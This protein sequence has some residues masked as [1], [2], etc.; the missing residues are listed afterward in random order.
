MKIPLFNRA[1]RGKGTPP[2]CPSRPRTSAQSLQGVGGLYYTPIVAFRGVTN[3]ALPKRF[4]KVETSMLAA[5]RTFAKSWVAAV[6]IGLLVVILFIFLVLSP[7]I[8]YIVQQYHDF[9]NQRII[10]VALVL[11]KIGKIL[12]K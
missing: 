4:A 6:L 3:R 5:I 7:L 8:Y 1:L 10:G 11:D 9:I 2:T 12:Y